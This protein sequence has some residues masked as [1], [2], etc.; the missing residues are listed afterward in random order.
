MTSA[1]SIV[2]AQVIAGHKYTSIIPPGPLSL[3]H[4]RASTH[5]LDVMHS[6]L[7]PAGGYAIGK[8]H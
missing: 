1:W 6:M 5:G 3:P 4:G 2:L 8:P 7:A